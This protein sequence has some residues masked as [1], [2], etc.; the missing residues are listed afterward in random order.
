MTKRYPTLGIARILFTSLWLLYCIPLSANPPA[1]DHVS[2]N[3]PSWV[4]TWATALLPIAAKDMPPKPGLANHVLRQI[5]CVSIGGDKLK[6]KFSNQFGKSPLVIK[7]VQIGVAKDSSDIDTSTTALLTFKGKQQVTIPPGTEIYADPISYN[8]KPRARIAITISFG[9]V[10]LILTGHGGSRTTSYLLADTP[11]NPRE[12]FKD[13]IRIDHW[14]VIAGIEVEAKNRSGAVVVFGDSITDGRGS[15]TN[16]QNRWPDIL[17]ENLLKDPATSNVGVVNMG[18][19][20]NCVLKG[21]LGPTGLKR[22]EHDVLNQ[23]SVRWLIIAEGVND[24]GSTPDSL[25]ADEVAKNLIAAYQKFIDLAHAKGIKVYGATIMPFKKSF[26]DAG[27]RISARNKVNEWIRTSNR[28]DA[29]IDFDY[30][31]RDADD[32]D[33]LKYEVQAGAN[34]FLHPNEHGYRLMGDSIDLSLFK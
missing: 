34:D 28:F 14:Y 29:V 18:I 6:L 31:M 22:F 8:L 16:K 10:P 24:L 33:A 2:Q 4:G 7:S 1:T 15:G 17:S 13:A 5:V 32:K 19:G 26:Y 9:D 25:A 27:Y 3:S 30:L 11:A 21:G 20:G 23:N 12:P